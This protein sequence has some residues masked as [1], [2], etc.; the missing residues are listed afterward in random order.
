MGSVESLL[1]FVAHSFLEREF[2]PWEDWNKYFTEVRAQEYS[3]SLR[4]IDKKFPA[5]DT[6]NWSLSPN[7]KKGVGIV[8]LRDERNLSDSLVS[9]VLI[10]WEVLTQDIYLVE[11]G[12]M[13]EAAG[14]KDKFCLIVILSS[15]YPGWKSIT[16]VK[17][18]CKFWGGHDLKELLELPW[19]ASVNLLPRLFSL[20]DSLK[21]PQR[22]HPAIW[23]SNQQTGNV[24]GFPK[25][26]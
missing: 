5:K 24:L 12:L 15:A 2:L 14:F 17:I 10:K 16:L 20:T 19:V 4:G 13:K 25:Y 22:H 26:L 18:G 7:T 23:C 21:Q 3:S 11:K 8:D 1:E 9:G 6:L